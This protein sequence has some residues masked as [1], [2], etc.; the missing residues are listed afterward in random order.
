MS[1]A[2]AF[3]TFD[4]VA[5]EAITDND[6]IKTKHILYAPIFLDTSL[7]R[8]GWIQGCIVCNANT[9]NTFFYKDKTYENIGYMVYCCRTCNQVKENNIVIQKEYNDTI[10]DYVDTYKDIIYEKIIGGSDIIKK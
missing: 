9:S 2:D 7:P 3:V 1:E 6:D 10:I 4:T 5:F 8:N